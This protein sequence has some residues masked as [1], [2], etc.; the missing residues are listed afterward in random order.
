MQ[1]VEPSRSNSDGNLKKSQLQRNDRNSE[2]NRSE[3]KTTNRHKRRGNSQ[4]EAATP[5]G[6]KQSEHEPVGSVM[7]SFDRLSV[8]ASPADRHFNS[9]QQKHSDT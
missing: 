2:R 1:S 9:P 5:T 7:S 6:N 8:N 3:M 4:R